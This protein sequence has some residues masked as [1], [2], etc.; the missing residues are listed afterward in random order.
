MIPSIMA[1]ERVQRRI[2]DL[3]DRAETA[4]DEMDWGRVRDLCDAVLRLDPAKEDA[5]E[6][7]RDAGY[8]PGAAWPTFQRSG[9]EATLW[10]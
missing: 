9:G 5:L 2:D 1:S 7:C 6:F 4:V 8:R 3:L 10:L